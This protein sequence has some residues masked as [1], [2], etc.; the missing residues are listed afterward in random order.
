M[1]ISSFKKEFADMTTY[2]NLAGHKVQAS[3]YRTLY[4]M[5]LAFHIIVMFKT[6]I[7]MQE[8][9]VILNTEYASI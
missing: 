7:D 9:R 1:L 6:V 5:G 3:E 2:A 4:A 8:T